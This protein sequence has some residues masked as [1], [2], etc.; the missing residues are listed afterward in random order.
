MNN[1]EQQMNILDEN[2]NSNFDILISS[3]LYSD[4]APFYFEKIVS[5]K[6]ISDYEQLVLEKLKKLK[7]DLNRLPSFEYCIEKNIVCVTNVNELYSENV[8]KD[9]LDLFLKERE[10]QFSAETLHSVANF[11][12]QKGIPQNAES[13]VTRALS[14]TKN[15]EY[16]NGIKEFPEQYR[17]KELALGFS[18][19][20]DTIDNET[21][22]FHRGTLNTILGFAGSGKTTWAVNVAYNATFQGVNVAYISLEISKN[23][24]ICDLLSRHSNEPTFSGKLEHKALK[25]RTLDEKDEKY[26][27][28]NIYP[29]F[30]ETVGKHF[31][32]ID[33]SDIV[34]YS[35]TFFSSILENLDKK[36]EKETGKGI[37][38][39]FVDHVQLLKASSSLGIR[40][41]REII[42]L[43][44]SFFRKHAV[45]FLGTKRQVCIILLSQANR[46]GWK[47]AKKHNGVYQLSALAEANEL[48]RASNIVLS[49]YTDESMLMANQAKVKVCKSRDS[50]ASEETIDAYIDPAT[51]LFGD[52]RNDNFLQ[53]NVLE[54]FELFSNNN[55]TKLDGLVF[56][57]EN[58]LFKQVREEF[59]VKQ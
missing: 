29:H 17:N 24:L 12:E 2:N 5:C 10:K 31:Y 37:D 4:N 9:K 6:K 47:Y 11:I 20:V 42:N 48:E 59:N 40:D 35:P 16:S 7:N 14:Q 27:F 52:K 22:G 26:L 36:F 53:N 34:E 21:G 19:C 54:M 18:T 13:I 57:E 30:A 25:H 33:E 56:N 44:V 8:L 28:D 1:L 23:H 39:I 49:I 50:C 15:I 32:I 43:F 45:N 38:L 46:E 3:I 58:D 41:T 55:D 51:Y